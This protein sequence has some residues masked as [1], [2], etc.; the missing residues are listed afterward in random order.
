M[1]TIQFVILTF[2]FACF[3][4]KVSHSGDFD[5]S[6]PLLFSVKSILEC[7]PNGE[8]RMVTAE[9]MEMP[10]FL[11]VDCKKMT[12]SP[13]PPIAGRRDTIIK[14]MERINGKLFLQ[15]ADGGIEN[16]RDGV[17]WT[18]EIS[19]DTGRA[20]VTASGDDVGF[21]IFGACLPR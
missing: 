21:V 19:E 10:Q 20:V 13:L 4:S 16:V 14:R 8:S 15:G 2:L 9:E 1:K 18:A 6:R 5:G 12:I 7:T 17:G 11:I 3:V